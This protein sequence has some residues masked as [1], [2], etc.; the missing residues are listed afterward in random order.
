MLVY[1]IARECPSVATDVP[2]NAYRGMFTHWCG[3]LVLY[4]IYCRKKIDTLDS[5][6]CFITKW[7]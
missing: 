1:Y 6:M 4:I 7:I 3:R 5:H 2:Y